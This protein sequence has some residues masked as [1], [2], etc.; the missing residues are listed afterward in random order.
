MRG[1]TWD[2]TWACVCSGF[3]PLVPSLCTP[4]VA[5]D[6]SGGRGRGYFCISNENCMHLV[7]N[8]YEDGKLSPHPSLLASIEG[9]SL[10]PS[11]DR[12]HQT[13][14]ISVSQEVLTPLHPC[15]H[16]KK[17][18]RVNSHYSR[19]PHSFSTYCMPHTV[20]KDSQQPCR[21]NK[22]VTLLFH[23]CKGEK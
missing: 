5:E 16:R 17:N 10:T 7:G 11:S 20:H 13:Q 21:M 15:T 9:V 23:S 1:C 19:S 22:I 3:P 12:E 4:L 18:K 6:L 14:S 8:E 2:G